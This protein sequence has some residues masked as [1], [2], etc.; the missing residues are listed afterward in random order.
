MSKHL[1]KKKIT[2]LIIVVV[3]VAAAIGGYWYFKS[4][5]TKS[6]TK[7]QKSANKSNQSTSNNKPVINV[8]TPV[9]VKSTG[10]SGPITKGT[11]VD[12]TC[13]GPPGYACQL[14]LKPSSGS[15]PTFN[16]KNLT[17]DSRG[18]SFANWEWKAVAGSWQAQVTLFNSGGQSQTS[19][20][21]N[22]DV[23]WFYPPIWALPN[24]YNSHTLNL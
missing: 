24:H 4:N 11:V 3:V 2:I 1:S 14:T 12:F 17:S 19:D 16:K 23:K 15:A 18:Q 7:N 21:Q 20:V 13:F 6:K 9:L 8:P 22:F 5:A 10:N